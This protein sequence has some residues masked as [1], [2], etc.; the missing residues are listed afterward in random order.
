MKGGINKVE[1][2]ALPSTGGALGSSVFTLNQIET[3]TYKGHVKRKDLTV[4]WS[5]GANSPDLATF[6]DTYLTTTSSSNDEVLTYED[7]TTSSAASGTVPNLFAHVYVG[8]DSGYIQ[9]YS[10]ACLLTENTGDHAS[11]GGKI[12]KRA[13]EVKFQTWS[14]TASVTGIKSKYNAICDTTGTPTGNK[15]PLDTMAIN[16][17]A[18]ERWIKKA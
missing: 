12:Q 13:L 14:G 4:T 5:Q 16:D 1:F 10:G 3:G 18:V 17:Y 7:N 11:G 15:V 6:L 2:F 8:E 9:V